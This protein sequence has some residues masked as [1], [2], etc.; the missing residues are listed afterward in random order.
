MATDRTALQMASLK[1]NFGSLSLPPTGNATVMFPRL[2]FIR[3]VSIP[4]GRPIC[5]CALSCGLAFTSWSRL[6]VVLVFAASASPSIRAWM[7]DVSRPSTLFHPA[8]C[9]T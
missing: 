7:V 3:D 1:S 9:S 8:C 5:A 4:S 2:S 6:I